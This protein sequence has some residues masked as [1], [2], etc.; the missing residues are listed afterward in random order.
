MKKFV[1]KR[2]ST[3]KVKDSSFTG[4]R[5]PK[6]GRKMDLKSY[7]TERPETEKSEATEEGKRKK[8]NA[9]P[10]EEPK[11]DREDVDSDSWWGKEF[12]CKRCSVEK[13]TRTDV[14][15]TGC[16]ECGEEMTFWRAVKG[17]KD[18]DRDIHSKDQSTKD[19]SDGKEWW[20]EGRW[21]ARWWALP[22]GLFLFEYTLAVQSGVI[23]PGPGRISQAQAL[24]YVSLSA[25][26][27]VVYAWM[28]AK[29]LDWKPL[30][31]WKRRPIQWFLSL[32]AVF[33]PVGLG[34]V[35]V[36]ASQDPAV[37]NSLLAGTAIFEAAVSRLYFFWLT[38]LRFGS[39]LEFDDRSSSSGKR[40]PAGSSSGRNRKF[41][42]Y[43]YVATNPNIEGLVKIGY[44]KRTVEKRMK[45]LSSSTGVPGRYKA[46][47]KFKAVRPKQLERKVHRRL[48]S[49]RVERGGEF[50][51]VS[52]RKGARVI[53][54]VSG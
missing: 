45:E 50:F 12:V 31:E 23:N 44:T 41:R 39:L 20:G 40:T 33:G 37:E 26:V 6:C 2:C 51:K 38:S 11:R 19:Q 4:T 3:E 29:E 48:S 35:Y 49:Q 46:K 27:C 15:D 17:K 43:V 52:P 5:C 30:D 28:L 53:K 21:W 8:V 1:C 9:A 34:M 32:L 54:N 42:G 10:S 22:L 14:I 24:L 47:Y 18:P 16:P 36:S 13:V 7:T 25:P